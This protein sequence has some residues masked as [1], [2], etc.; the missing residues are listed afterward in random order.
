MRENKFQ[1]HVILRLRLEFPTCVVVK[2][3]TS[4]LQGIPDLSIFWGLN[5]GMLECKADA[6]SPFQPNQE[7]YIQL[8]NMMSF[9]KVIY[10]ANE[11]E[12]FGALQRAFAG[13]R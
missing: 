11:D 1:R 5:W 2:N 13:P 12:V 10:P 7:H 8:F 9:C 4:Y 6:S 3:D